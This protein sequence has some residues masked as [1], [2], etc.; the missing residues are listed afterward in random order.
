MWLGKK[1]TRTGMED[2]VNYNLVG[3]IYTLPPPKCWFG[4]QEATYFQEKRGRGTI[5]GRVNALHRTMVKNK[6]EDDYSG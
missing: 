4:Y 3:L 1:K 5:Q 2:E 6:Y